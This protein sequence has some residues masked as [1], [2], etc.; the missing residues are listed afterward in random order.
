[1][2]DSEHSVTMMLSN[3]KAGDE[4]AAYEIWNR[5]FDRVR[6]LAKKKLGRLPSRVAEDEDIALSAMHALYQG[7]QEGRFRE[8]TDRDDL[9]QILCMITS[10]KAAS[11]WRKKAAVQEVG[12]S[13]LAGSR[14]GE[15]QLGIQHIANNLPDDAYVDSLSQTTCELLEDLDTRQREIAMLRLHGFTNS[16]IA[17]KINRSIKTVERYLKSI[18][19]QWNR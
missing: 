7:A 17:E 3:L 18:R 8:L 4:Q 5:F 15:K 16:E 2:S 9:W 12:E 1:M 13:V 6:G 10:R 14:G 11:A 19:E